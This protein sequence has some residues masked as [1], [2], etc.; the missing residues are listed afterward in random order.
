MESVRGTYTF[1]VKFNHRFVTV[2]SL[3]LLVFLFA[4]CK[5]SKEKPCDDYRQAMRDF[6]VRISETAKAQ[7]VDFVVILQNGIE[8]VTLDDDASANLATDYLAV[9]DGHGQEDLFYGY[10]NDNT[11]TSASTTAYLLSYLHRS[12]QVG[13]SILVTDYC[14]RSDYVVDAHHRCDAE[15]LLSF[16]ASSRELDVIPTGA[17]P[18]ENTQNIVR[19]SD[20]RNFLYLLN[21]EKYTSKTKFIEAVSATNY[22][23]VIMDLFFYDGTA[24]TA[25]EIESLKFKANGGKR[26]VI[27]YMSVGEAEDYRYYW[28][29]SWSHYEPAWLAHE[30]PSWPGNYKVRYW[31]SE[32]QDIICG[33]GD[34][35]LNRILNA[36]F[37][38]VYLDIIDAFEFFE[39]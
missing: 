39:N 29:S 35:Y 16:T 10:T 8:L 12:Q 17:I 32:W 34:S 4:T 24:F 30:N 33:S 26:L 9:I 28:Q 27:C 38:G 31:Y 22:D 19:L 6:V 20:A 14:T 5:R 13:K 1:H 36:H 37:D 18:H 11:P 7:D 21:N 15:G 2:L 25:S 3:C 23:L